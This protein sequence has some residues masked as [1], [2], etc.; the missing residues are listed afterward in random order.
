MQI[1]YNAFIKAIYKYKIDFKVYI[2]Q[3]I[4]QAFTKLKA[5][6]LD[7]LYYCKALLG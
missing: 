1:R 5:A 7:A 3:L 2:R 6:K 4:S